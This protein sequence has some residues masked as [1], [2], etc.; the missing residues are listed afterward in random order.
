MQINLDNDDIKNAARR[1]VEWL[2]SENKTPNN[3][4]EDLVIL[5]YLLSGLY[6]GTFTVSPSSLNQDVQ[7]SIVTVD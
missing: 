2:S 4:N 6:N 5:K 7:D 1:G 3:W